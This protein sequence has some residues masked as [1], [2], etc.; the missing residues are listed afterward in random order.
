[1][2]EIIFDNYIWF[3]WSIIIT[4]LFVLVI[5]VYL[6]SENNKLAESGKAF[7]I[8]CALVALG[9]S[10]DIKHL[11]INGVFHLLIAFSIAWFS[12]RKYKSQISYLFYAPCVLIL[13]VIAFN[14]SHLNIGLELLGRWSTL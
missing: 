3:S 7:C 9:M 12:V 10:G 6:Q 5:A 13:I 11:N 4:S 14:F 1:M 2:S 8:F